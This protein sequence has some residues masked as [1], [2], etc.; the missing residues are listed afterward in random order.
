MFT[1]AVFNV[2]ASYGW[3]LP[4]LVLTIFLLGVL[5]LIAY[6]AEDLPIDGEIFDGIGS[7]FKW[8]R[9]WWKRGRSG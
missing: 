4:A 6:A 8:T 3:I 2:Y 9:R 7:I 5:L 1:S